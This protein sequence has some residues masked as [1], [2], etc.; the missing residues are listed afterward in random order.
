M[1]V[2]YHEIALILNEVRKLTKRHVGLPVSNR[3]LN[4]ISP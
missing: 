4:R 2:A 3:G 1:S